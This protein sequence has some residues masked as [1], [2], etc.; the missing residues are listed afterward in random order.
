M[1][2]PDAMKFVVIGSDHAPCSGACVLEQRGL[3]RYSY[4]EWAFKRCFHR[5]IFKPT[6]F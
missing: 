1:S 2:G 4:V 5:I 3:V 6:I